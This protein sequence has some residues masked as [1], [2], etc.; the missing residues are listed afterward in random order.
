VIRVDFADFD[1]SVLN[2][3]RDVLTRRGSRF[4][5]A[6]PEGPEGVLVRIFFLEDTDAPRDEVRTIAFY[7]TRSQADS[8]FAP[9][10]E[11][12]VTYLASALVGT[13]DVHIFEILPVE[14]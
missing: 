6:R 14:G 7:D 10:G 3:K 11:R 4:L 5:F 1:Q 2:E 8:I 13:T 9:S 12:R